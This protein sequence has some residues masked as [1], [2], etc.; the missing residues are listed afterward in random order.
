LQGIYIIKLQE[1]AKPF[2][3]S[4]PRRVAI[5]LLKSVKQELQHMDDLKVIVRVNEPT[6]WCGGAEIEQQSE[7]LCATPLKNFMKTLV[8][9]FSRFGIPSIKHATQLS[10]LRVSDMWR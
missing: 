3:I 1:V 5:P 8:M 7:D 10:P 9:L 6:E 4:T 2:A